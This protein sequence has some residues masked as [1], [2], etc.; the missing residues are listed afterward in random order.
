MK[1][2]R[3]RQISNLVDGSVV[4]ER[5]YCYEPPSDILGMLRLMLDSCSEFMKREGIPISQNSIE[6]QKLVFTYPGMAGYI[7]V[8]M[9]SSNDT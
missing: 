7:E 5:E 8:E 6:L 2:M 9:G 4:G 1:S 3:L